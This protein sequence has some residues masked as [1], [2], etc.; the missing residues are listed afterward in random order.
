M[1]LRLVA[2]GGRRR[3][4]CTECRDGSLVRRDGEGNLAY[5]SQVVSRLFCRAVLAVRWRVALTR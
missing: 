1:V 5:V 3:C 2:R 4:R